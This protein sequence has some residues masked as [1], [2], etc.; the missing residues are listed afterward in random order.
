MNHD[1]IKSVVQEKF[2]S[3]ERVTALQYDAK[4]L[5]PDWIKKDR[6]LAIVE[7]GDEKAVFCL[8]TSCYPPKS[9]TDLSIEIVLPIDKS[10]KC[11]ID[12][13]PSDPEAILYLNL[14]S[15]NNKYK[16]EIQMTPRVDNFVDDLF[17]GIEAVN[18]M[19]TQPEF[20]WLKKYQGKTDT[21]MLSQTMMLPGGVPHTQSSAP[22][23]VRES[24]I[25]HKMYDKEYEYTFTKKI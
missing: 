9:F 14:Q 20:V 7:F 25:K 15:R 5:H 24:L 10:F 17:R 8:F 1:D 4:V 12:N 21:D 23:A 11:E 13:K 2:L 19:P 6:L 3:S 18:K 16:F 22:V